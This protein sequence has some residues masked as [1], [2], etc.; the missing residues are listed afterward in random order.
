MGAR[1]YLQVTSIR[2]SPQTYSALVL[3]EV[4]HLKPFTKFMYTD[5]PVYS[6]H[7]GIPLPPKLGVISLKRFWSGDLTNARLVE[8]LEAV[9]PGICYLKTTRSSCRSTI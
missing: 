6:F 7:A 2:R 4:E 9:K 5:D 8:E 1:V 3:A